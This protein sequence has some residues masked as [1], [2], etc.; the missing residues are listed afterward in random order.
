MTH[1]AA[2]SIAGLSEI[3]NRYDV[4]LCDVWG[5]V[6]NG[7]QS[8][9]PACDALVRFQAEPGPVILSRNAPRPPGP[10]FDQLDSLG[11]PRQA[12]GRVVTSGDVT[13]ALLAERAPGPVYKLGPERDWPLY[14]GLG[15]NESGLEE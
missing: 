14:E 11:V 9:R 13:R 6:H 4:L 15:L 12:W 3:A 7:R 2:A 1:P 5:V 10:I 8:F